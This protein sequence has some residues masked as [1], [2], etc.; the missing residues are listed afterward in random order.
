M[1]VVTGLLRPGFSR[2]VGCFLASLGLHVLLIFF[3]SLSG[4]RSPHPAQ[5]DSRFLPVDVLSLNGVLYPETSVLLDSR[6][7]VEIEPN[8]QPV[9][10]TSNET[11]ASNGVHSLLQSAIDDDS[12]QAQLAE[13]SALTSLHQPSNPVLQDTTQP[14]LN[15]A[16]YLTTDALDVRPEPIIIPDEWLE[17]LSNNLD[18]NLKFY[19]SATG[20][21]DFVEVI[22]ITKDPENPQTLEIISSPGFVFTP[23]VID[24]TAVAVKMM[25]RF[26][27]SNESSTSNLAGQHMQLIPLGE[28]NSALGQ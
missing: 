17:K 7:T 1:S 25:I 12:K 21:V 10:S 15:V 6:A 3:V 19:I 24:K 11:H 18:I 20:E 28:T 14:V 5:A 23:G 8:H 16:K 2:S 26:N 4:H 9:T 22:D 13:S 27:I